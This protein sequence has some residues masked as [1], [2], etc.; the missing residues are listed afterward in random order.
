MLRKFGEALFFV[1]VLWALWVLVGSNPTQRM[2][3]GCT[4]VSGPGSFLA[5]L[6]SAANTDWGGSIQ[7]WTNNGAYRCQLTLWNFYYAEDWKREH[8]G[9][10]LPGQ[11]GGV[12]IASPA[13]SAPAGPKPKPG[14]ATAHAPAEQQQSTPQ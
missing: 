13:G 7:T 2:E 9:Q 12:E 5:S 8:P 4:L 14:S 3:R 10:P 11:Q 6:A 1:F